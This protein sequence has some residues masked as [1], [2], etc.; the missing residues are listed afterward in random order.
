M[1]QFTSYRRRKI[2]AASLL[3]IAVVLPFFQVYH[4]YAFIEFFESFGHSISYANQISFATRVLIPSL[5]MLI[6]YLLLIRCATNKPC[7]TALIILAANESLNFLINATITLTGITIVP[8]NGADF[9]SILFVIQS[10]ISWLTKFSFIYAISLIIRNGRFADR[11]KSWVTILVVLSTLSLTSDCLFVIPH[12]DDFG[13]LFSPVIH[14]GWVYICA[15]MEIIAY[16]KLAMSDTFSEKFYEPAVRPY[17]PVNRYVAS[18]L[19]AT[20]ITLAALWVYYSFCADY[21]NI[22]F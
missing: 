7:R 4:Y 20:I 13:S 10:I 15:I 6:A 18:P 1:D 21:I 22:L 2:A 3:A 5:P 19:F 17:T 11:A 16:V 9:L 14:N 12:R 8:D